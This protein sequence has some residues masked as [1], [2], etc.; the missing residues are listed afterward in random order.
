MAIKE[1]PSTSSRQDLRRKSALR[2]MLTSTFNRSKDGFF[3]DGISKK[4]PGIYL[5]RTLT[6]ERRLLYLLS[7]IIVSFRF[8]AEQFNSRLPP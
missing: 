2:M 1:I 5:S 3:G 7:P 6:I 8:F 4:P